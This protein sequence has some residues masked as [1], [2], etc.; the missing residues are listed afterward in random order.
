[1]QYTTKQLPK[2]L[3]E[4]SL[5]VSAE[6]LEKFVPETVEEL[7]KEIKVEGF[8][9]GKAPYD[10]LKAQIGEMK[11]YEH[12]AEHAI[13]QC[14]GKILEKENINALGAPRFEIQ[15]IAPHNPVE[16]KISVPLFPKITKLAN[17]KKIQIP[18]KK[19]NIG[20][21][22]IDKTLSEIQKM[23]TIEKVIDREAKKEDK[24]VVDMDII[25][26]GVPIEGG[27][28]KNHAVYLNEPYYI[29][30]FGE[31]LIGM[32]RGETRE[33]KLPFPKEHYQKNIAGREVDF[34]VKACDVYELS[35]PKIDDEFAKRLGKE[36]LVELKK[37]IKQNLEEEAKMK[38]TE[39][40]EVAI[41]DE[42]VKNSQFEDIPDALTNREI[43]KMIA[44]YKYEI[45]KY[46]LKF[47]DYL[48]SI[49][50]SIND[51]RLDFAAKA[52]ERVKASLVV[53]E[54]A[55]QEKIKADDKEVMAEIERQLNLYKDDPSAQEEIRKPEYQNYVR[56]FLGNRKAVDFLRER[57]VK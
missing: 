15:K 16:V 37:L 39:R 52:A 20:G 44:E 43:E 26:D 13:W 46:G 21:D 49:K 27:Q 18:A 10:V 3:L 34:K 33:F 36:N 28:A 7:S 54:I 22:E 19:I 48:A 1:M 24:I 9:P 11:I 38:E 57:C 42:L 56:T 8:R 40:Q 47:E 5:T 2:S 55:E 6:E 32:K 35:S 41:L 25:L 53:R 51:L 45:A 30:G 29:P 50:K 17:W 23:Q 12:A 14:Y 31:K 4:I